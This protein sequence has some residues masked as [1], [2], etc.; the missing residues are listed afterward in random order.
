M[1]LFFILGRVLI[2]LTNISTIKIKKN[3]ENIMHANNICKK[4]L[5]LD[6][7]NLLLEN[8]KIPHQPN[9]FTYLLT[10]Y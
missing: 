1:L 6:N 10:K 5:K 8:R 7:R 2:S 3:W 9:P 4:G